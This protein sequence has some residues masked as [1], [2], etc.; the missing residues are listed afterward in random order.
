MFNRIW[1]NEEGQT[2]A[3]TYYL[4]QSGIPPDLRVKIWKDLFK[5]EIFEFEETKI[6][7]KKYA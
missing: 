4:V 7:K 1:D 5:T 2:Y 3:D 6:F